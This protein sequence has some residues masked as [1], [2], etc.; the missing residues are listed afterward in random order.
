MYVLPCVN[1]VASEVRICRQIFIKVTNMNF[2]ENPLRGRRF[3]LVIFGQ[4]DGRTDVMM[5]VV[6]AYNLFKK[7]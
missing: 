3:C 4:T 5:L 2:H 1:S 7:H 6:D